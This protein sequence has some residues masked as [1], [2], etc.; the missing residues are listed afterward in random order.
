[1]SASI[2]TDE[3]SCR[4]HFLWWKT[5][6]WSPLVWWFRAT[7]RE[8]TFVYYPR[9]HDVRVVTI[10]PL[11]VSHCVESS[12]RR[13]IQAHRRWSAFDEPWSWDSDFNSGMSSWVKCLLC[14]LLAFCFVIV[15][16]SSWGF[17]C[18]F[19]VKTLIWVK[20]WKLQEECYL[21]S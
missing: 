10:L 5:W 13:H 1:M 20:H 3:W 8:V 21:C 2:R 19:V 14:A 12:S 11:R 9:Q 17:V 16:F 4:S 7:L 6:F 15:Y 18:S